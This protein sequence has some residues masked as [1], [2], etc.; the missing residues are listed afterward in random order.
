[1]AIR[2]GLKISL[3]KYSAILFLCHPDKS[4]MP[5]LTGLSNRPLHGKFFR[6]CDR[7]I[8]DNCRSQ[9]ACP[10]QQSTDERFE[11]LAMLFELIIAGSKSNNAEQKHHDQPII[12]AL[13]PIDIAN[14][15]AEQRQNFPNRFRAVL[16]NARCRLQHCCQK[17]HCGRCNL[18]FAKGRDSTARTK[19]VVVH[20]L[21]HK[22]RFVCL[23][24]QIWG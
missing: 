7:H 18:Q 22:T 14:V 17:A 23:A 11:I 24:C 5:I 8:N 13:M 20:R 4:L 21:G 2:P 10:M 9:A 3:Q 6:N 15:G 19:N 12:M 1:M 16:S